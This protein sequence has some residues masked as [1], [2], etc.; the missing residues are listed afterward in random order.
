MQGW[1][2]GRCLGK[3]RGI[4]IPEKT[5][6][7]FNEIQSLLKVRVTWP[8]LVG[9]QELWSDLCESWWKPN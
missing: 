8:D 7:L 2:N 9:A 6:K 5:L 1:N 4:R 3:D